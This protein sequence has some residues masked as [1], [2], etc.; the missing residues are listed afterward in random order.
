MI[1]PLKTKTTSLVLGVVFHFFVPVLW[2]CVVQ[3]WVS[4]KTKFR[5]DVISRKKRKSREKRN[6]M[7]SG[8]PHSTAFWYLFVLVTR[9]FCFRC[10]P[11]K[12][13]VHIYRDANGV[14]EFLELLPG[15]IFGEQPF[16]RS[17]LSAHWID[18]CWVLVLVQAGRRTDP[19]C[20]WWS[21]ALRRTMHCG[22]YDHG[23][24]G[25]HVHLTKIFVRATI[26]KKFCWLWGYLVV[27]CVRLRL[28]TEFMA[29]L[30]LHK[31]SVIRQLCSEQ[32][33]ALICSLCWT[34]VL[35]QI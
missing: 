15:S 17:V 11:L 9:Q 31:R 1:F 20:C 33:C 30:A 18:S 16:R 4:K 12:G 23:C 24:F 8:R 2:R 14:G 21:C 19:C 29:T 32:S 35:W 3:V 34:W 28:Q 10:L 22:N 27:L 7:Q 5:L 25:G 13:R 6:I 26:P